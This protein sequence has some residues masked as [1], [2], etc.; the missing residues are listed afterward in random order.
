MTVRT[1]E[2]PTLVL[3]LIEWVGD[4]LRPYRE[5]MEAWQTSCPRLPIWE[6]AL[7]HGFVERTRDETRGLSVKVTPEGRRFVLEQRPAVRITR[8]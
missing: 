6:D 2:N 8:N 7:E 3:D 1:L 4:G 5:V